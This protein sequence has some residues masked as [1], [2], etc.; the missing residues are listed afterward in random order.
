M[1]FLQ[2]KYSTYVLFIW[3]A[4]TGIWSGVMMQNAMKSL[5]KASRSADMLD[6]KPNGTSASVY[7]Y[8]D[9]TGDEGRK[10]LVGIYQFE[11]FIF[12]M[13]YGPFLIL[14][15]AYF[16]FKSFPNKKYLCW[17]CIVPVLGVC[18]DY[19]EN[20]SIIHI[21]ESYPQQISTASILGKITLA[22]WIT[23]GA[24]GLLLI[25]SLVFFITK[26]YFQKKS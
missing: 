22:K 24:S 11:D 17:L 8:L 9:R 21:I 14:A 19:I 10:V 3:F 4:F 23:A 7:H 12:P 20:F 2:S 26:R 25:I 16:F 13:A 18:F 15:I 5:K 1:R 6:L